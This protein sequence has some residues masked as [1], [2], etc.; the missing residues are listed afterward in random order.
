MTENDTI[1]RVHE[2]R[3]MLIQIKELKNS[4]EF[5]AEDGWAVGSSLKHATALESTIEIGLW[6]HDKSR[7]EALERAWETLDDALNS[8]DS[9]FQ[10][11]EDITQC[12]RQAYD[13]VYHAKRLLSEI[14]KEGGKNEG[15]N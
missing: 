9:A 10:D 13:E 8:L 11:G 14:I 1:I 3:R 4:L 2:A 12:A 6:G 5:I 15:K 7:K